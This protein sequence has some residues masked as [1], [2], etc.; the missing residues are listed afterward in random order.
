MIAGVTVRALA[1][2][3]A[4]SGYQV[5][6]IDGFGDRDLRA[7]AEAIVTRRDAAFDPFLAAA[8]GRHILAGAVAYTSNLENYP[9]AVGRLAGGRRL[10]GNPPAV[11]VRVRDPLGLMRALRRSGFPVP[12]TRASAPASRATGGWLLKPRRSGGGHGT[13]TWRPGLPVPGRCYLQQRISGAPGSLIFAADRRRIVPLGLTRQLVGERSFGAKGFRYVGSLLGPGLFAGASRLE[14]RMAEL[15][16]TVTRE[17]GLVG[18]NGIDFIAQD[19]VPFPI[20]VNPRYCASMELVERAGGLSVFAL[21][22]R[23]CTEGLRAVAPPPPVRGIVGKAIVYARRRVSVPDTAAWLAGG[24]IAD[25]P[26]PGERI[27]RGRPICTVFAEGRNVEECHRRLL[28]Q[29]EAVYRA[30]EPA[31]RGAA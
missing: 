15:A 31:V 4:R 13:R 18:L 11:L 2:S 23:A 29:A 28:S 25:V 12:A 14:T 24:T 30:V 22:H 19:D 21:H 16:E 17:F 7:A 26:H 10:L 6:A 9:V 3:A 5:I 27:A 20:E 1:L 8:A